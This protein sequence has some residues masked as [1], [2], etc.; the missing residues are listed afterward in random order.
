[1]AALVVGFV[2]AGPALAT[3]GLLNTGSTVPA[4]RPSALTAV[5]GTALRDGVHLTS[6]R[7]AD[8]AG[9]PAWGLRLSVTTRDNVCLMVGRVVGGKLGALGIDYSFHDDGRF[10]PFSSGYSAGSQCAELDGAGHAFA[11][12]DYFAQATSGYDGRYGYCLAG[13]FGVT[14]VARRRTLHLP[15][16]AATHA[17]V[18][19]SNSLRDIYYGVLGP[20]ATQIAYRVA[21]GGLRIERPVGPDGAYLIVLRH[22]SRNSPSSGSSP[23]D[24]LVGVAWRTGKNCGVLS[25]TGHR[26]PMYACKIQGYVAPKL[27]LPPASAVRSP[28]IVRL[29]PRNPGEVTVSFVSRVAITNE[30]S[31]Y[32][33]NV[34]DAPHRDPGDSPNDACGAA[35]EGGGTYRDIHVGERVRLQ[36]G[37][38]LPCYGPVR[39]VVDLV[40]QTGASA[41]GGP[42]FAPVGVGV[43]RIVGRFSYVVP[44]RHVTVPRRMRRSLKRGPTTKK[45]R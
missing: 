12:Y 28:L 3:V 32:S 10:H 14:F 42:A 38:G 25:H 21:G 1:V 20:D 44:K 22:S 37:E 8:P 9:G 36:I 11:W 43:H 31:Y 6:L 33:I 23:F 35:G 45:T 24:G 26:T 34:T 16:V 19:P 27:S 29:V 17:R 15:P 41:L 2:I 5:D 7:V 30:R 18:C 13:S 39:G 4:S 40:F